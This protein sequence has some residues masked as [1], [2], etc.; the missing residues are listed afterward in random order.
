M[1]AIRLKKLSRLWHVGTTDPA[2]KHGVSHEGHG[3]SVSLH[4]DEWRQIGRGKVGGDTWEMS[5]PDGAFLDIH[6]M[7]KAHVAAID[8]WAISVGLARRSPIYSIT[9]H[10]DD[11]VPYRMDFSTRAEAEGEMDRDEEEVIKERAGVLATH[12]LATRMGMPVDPAFVR[13]FL[14][15]AWTEDQTTLDGVW[16]QDRLDPA[17]LSAPRGVIL[18][19]SVANW[20]ARNLT[21]DCSH[22]V[23]M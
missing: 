11:D 19:R 3:L 5:R 8:D 13:D 20:D 21:A 6:R 18:P 12:S 14:A 23:G 10:D 16:W 2:R 4:P 17:A 7:S 9:R 22:R 15:V 1:T